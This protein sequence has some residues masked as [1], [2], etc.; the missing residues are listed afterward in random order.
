MVRLPSRNTVAAGLQAAQDALSQAARDL[1]DLSRAPWLRGGNT[2]VLLS[3][4]ERVDNIW[5]QVQALSQELRRADPEWEAA[6]ASE[7]RSPDL[8]SIFNDETG[9]LVRTTSNKSSRSDITKTTAKSTSDDAAPKKDGETESLGKLLML[10][11][12]Q[13]LLLVDDDPLVSRA[14]ERSLRKEF[15]VRVANTVNEALAAVDTRVPDIIVCDYELGDVTSGALLEIVA[16][17][18]PKMRRVLYSASQPELWQDLV[19]R[20]LVHATIMKPSS[21]DEL[22]STLRR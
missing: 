13:Q 3:A 5:L 7:E 8:S 22:V 19:E 12:R 16:A 9:E 4:M 18:H 21:F 10:P 14:L 20:E 17:R 1:I 11:R 6:L 15:D 2:Q